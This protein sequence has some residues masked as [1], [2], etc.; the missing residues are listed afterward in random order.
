MT[1]GVTEDHVEQATLEWLAALGWEVGHGPDGSPPDAKTP[2][3]E[4]DT[5]RETVLKHRLQGAI[6][7]LNPHIPAGAQDEACR[8]VLSPNL[9]G[10]VQANRQMH[11][12]MVEGVP[13]EYQKGGETRGDR[14]RLVDWSDVSRNDWLALNQFSIQGPK[15]TRRPDVVLFLNGLPVVVVELKNPGD[16]HADL[17][18]AFNQLQTYKDDIPNLFLSNALL[19]ISD[20]L[21]ARVGSLT[22]DRERFMAW[23]TIDGETVDPLGAMR[24]LE[25]LVHGLFQRELL[26]DYLRH[27]ILFEDEGRL[28]KKV[29]GY[30]QFHAV[31]AVVER[32]LVASSPQA[33]AAQRGKGGVVWHTQGAG[34][35]IEMTC[36]AAK[37]MQHPAMGNPTLVVV[38][39]RN[40]LDN[41]LFGVFAGAAE[42]LRETPVQA[43]RVR[44]FAHPQTR[45]NPYK[46][47]TCHCSPQMSVV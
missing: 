46:S 41:Q 45:T 25:T 31:R 10:L 15:R 47:T 43:A 2:G 20:G 35:S 37:L 3:T 8:Q 1:S 32:V 42:L 28:V 14:V 19:V 21:E 11:R 24:E 26:L 18:S 34:K 39:D 5:Y 4:R 17:W 22:A 38:T 23:R 9:P 13:V 30:H 40:D 16:E 27:F 36:L 33:E 6:R 44:H 7:R 12:W 29:A